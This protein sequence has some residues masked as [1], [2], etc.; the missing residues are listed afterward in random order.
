MSDNFKR[1]LFI[2]E[3][4]KRKEDGVITIPEIVQKLSAKGIGA[5]AYLPAVLIP[6]K[7]GKFKLDKRIK[8]S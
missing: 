1:R 8:K 5:A 2:L 3:M 7:L 6:V 4:L